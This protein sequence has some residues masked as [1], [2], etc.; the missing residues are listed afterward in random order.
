MSYI[1]SAKDEGA[2]IECGG[3]R[4]ALSGSLAN[5]YYISPCVLTNCRDDMKA[6]R[7]EIFGSV[8]AVLP[9]DTEEE[10]IKRANDT[11]FGLAGNYEVITSIF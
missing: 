6:V 4:V 10:V 8:A 2:T 9:F 11:P 3:E 5:G 7:E 1:K